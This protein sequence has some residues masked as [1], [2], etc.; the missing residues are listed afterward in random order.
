MPRKQTHC[1]RGAGHPAPCAS[2]EAMK[3]QRQ[4]NADR[5]PERVVTYEAKARWNKAYRLKCYGLTQEDFDRL[6]AEQDAACGMCCEP[7]EDGQLLVIDHAQR[8]NVPGAN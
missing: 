7:F 4:R 5:R 8:H 2:P 3:R 6:L 1:E